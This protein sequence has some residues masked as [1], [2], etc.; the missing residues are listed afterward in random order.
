[1]RIPALKLPLALAFVPTLCPGAFAAPPPGPLASPAP[2]KGWHTDERFGFKLKVPSKWTSIP[3][4]VD[5]T[6]MAAKFLSKKEYIYVD[7]NT[8]WDSAHKA[9]LVI[10]GFFERSEEEGGNAF[11]DELFGED[12]SDEDKDE[13]DEKEE[14]ADEGE[15]EGDGTRRFRIKRDPYRDYEDYL[16]RTWSNGGFYIYSTE[17]DEADGVPVTKYSIKVEKLST[18][19]RITT[20]VFHA[21]GVD[22]AVQFDVLEK[23]YRDL[24]RTMQTAFNSIEIIERKGEEIN[25]DADTW[26]TITDMTSG[27]PAE[28]REKRIKSEAQHPEKILATLSEGWEAKQISKCFVV[29]HTDDRYA[30]KVVAHCEGVLSWL[31]E[32]FPTIGP[33]E[34]V[35]APIIRIC[36]DQDEENAFKRGN[37]SW[38]TGIE[39]VTHKDNDGWGWEQEWTNRQILAHWFKER[40]HDLYGALPA[41][42]KEGLEEYVEDLRTKGRR[43]E[44]SQ[45]ESWDRD[46]LRMEARNGAVSSPREIMSEAREGFSMWST[47]NREAGALVAFL[48]SKTSKKSK[49]TRDLLSIYMQ[50]VGAAVDSLAEAEKDKE[51]EEYKKPETEEEEEAAFKA[52]QATYK[53]NEQ[54]LL[55]DAFFRTFRTWSDRD[56]EKFEKAFFEEIR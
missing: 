52:R 33:E 39:I 50:N 10:I 21:D 27:T 5:E 18:P 8:G 54:A 20:W 2:Q 53:K 51:P 30:K 36:K 42:L 15:D 16:D 46:R 4:K 34:Y 45:N 49:K 48:M 13:K 28:R 38:S 47:R 3:M 26:I 22:I 12:E 9:E 14:E 55:D 19:K 43:V 25:Q 23:E 56:W 1:M 17:E 6:W 29:N 32:T 24:R 37:G 44:Y 11:E 41:W 35:R 31:D 40:D 7:P